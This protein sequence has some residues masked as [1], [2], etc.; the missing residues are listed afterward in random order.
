MWRQRALLAAVLGL[1]AILPFLPVPALWFEQA[2]YI[3]LYALVVTGLVLL[4]G[5]TGLLSF[6]QAPFMGIAAYTSSWLCLTYGL[7]PWITLPISLL[8]TGISAWLLALVTLRMSGHYLP[9]ATIAWGIAL[10]YLFGSSEALGQYDGL[11]G[12]PPVTVFGVP[13]TDG[14]SVYWLVLAAVVLAVWA[15]RNLLDSHPGRAIRALKNGTRMPEAMGVDTWRVK[16]TVFV[17]SALL[18]ALAGWLYAHMLRGVSPQP[19]GLLHSLDYLIML[20]VGGMAHLGGAILGAALV[21]LLEDQLK[22]VLPALFGETGHAEVVVFGFILLLSLRFAPEGLWATLRRWLPERSRQAPVDAP[23]LASRAA[24][25]PGQPLLEVNELRKT[26]GGLAAV[27]G[28]SLRVATGEIVGLIGPN[29]AG[30]STTFN[31]IT[32]QLAPSGGDILLNGRSIAGRTPSEIASLAVSRTFQHVKLVPDMTVLEN[33]ALGAYLRAR[34]GVVQ[35][36]LRL[37][38]AMERR[39]LKEAERALR[40]VGLGEVLHQPAGSLALGQQRLV[41]IARAL[42][43][44]PVLLLL[45]EPAAGLRAFEKRALADLLSQLRSEGMAILL[46]EH[47]MEF[48]MQLT[49][50]I[51]VMVFGKKIAEGRPEAIQQDSAVQNAYLGEPA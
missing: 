31:L 5:V 15:C 18:A 39:L 48:V 34:V 12:V 30:K 13:L 25:T 20:V 43:S 11:T 44:D 1:S 38:R 3:G 14:R 17:I 2:N 29:G 47:D 46:V 33:V 50:H 22:V 37:D 40:R 35:A 16:V 4:T 23:A 19:F 51:V 10:Y 45:D 36:M 9:L 21:V 41:E 26:F 42:C 28:V 7:S 8:V 27:G 6:G 49:D 32:G 24:P